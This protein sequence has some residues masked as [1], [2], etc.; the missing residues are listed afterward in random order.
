M[1][2]NRIGDFSLLISILLIFFYYKA[3]DYATIVALTPMFK[4]ITFNFLTFNPKV[5]TFIGI[6]MFLGA[7]GKSAQLIL[8][9]VNKILLLVKL[10]IYYDV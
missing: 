6:F 3:I 9:N 2:L 10:K 8:H 4:N 7:I 1:I 5:L